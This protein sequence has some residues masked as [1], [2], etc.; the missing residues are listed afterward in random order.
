MTQ[1]L[2]MIGWMILS[3]GLAYAQAPTTQSSA[4]GGRL[5]QACLAGNAKDAAALLKDNPDLVNVRRLE[6][7]ATPLHLAKNAA[8]AAVLLENGADIEATDTENKCTPL[9]WAIDR[10]MWKIL[11]AHQANM[12]LLDRD[13]HESPMGWA[14][15][16]G[17]TEMVKFLLSRGAK[18]RQVDIQ[19][20]K[21]GGQGHNDAGR[22]AIVDD[23]KNIEKML[24]AAKTAR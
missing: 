21:T 23:Y 8:V 7:G 11:L 22:G 17:Q 9:H 20:A 24:V 2:A 10:E 6:D 13:Y 14:V 16:A 1:K 4:A 5:L 3:V 19:N 12:E 18:V 15:Y